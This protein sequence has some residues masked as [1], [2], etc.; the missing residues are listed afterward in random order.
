VF[1]TGISAVAAAAVILVCAGPAAADD[2]TLF[3]AYNSQQDELDRACATYHTAAKQWDTHPKSRRVL[4]ALI[5]GDQKINAVLHSIDTALALE[6]PS[7]NAGASAKADAR[8]EAKGW[9]RANGFEVRG[10]HRALAGDFVH[11]KSWYSHA[12][13]RMQRVY[14][15]GRDAVAEFRS[16]GLESTFGALSQ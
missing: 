2:A 9:A 11:A 6:A 7:S 10:L 16:V 14:R 13:R 1:R 8:A 12:G 5:L 15:S 3:A 4:R